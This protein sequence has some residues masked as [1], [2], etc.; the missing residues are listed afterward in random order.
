MRAAVVAL[1]DAAIPAKRSGRRK[2]AAAA[3]ATG[4]TK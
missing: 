3:R 2:G 4:R 1:L